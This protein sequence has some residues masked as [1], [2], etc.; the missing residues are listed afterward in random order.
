[1]CVCGSSSMC[2]MIRVCIRVCPAR[3]VT[4]AGHE[5]V[6]PEIKLSPVYQER[7]VDVFLYDE[8]FLIAYIIYTTS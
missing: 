4:D 6:D 7:I 2:C 1:M 3:V 8:C 5:C